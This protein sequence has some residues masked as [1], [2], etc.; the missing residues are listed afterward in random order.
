M[1]FMFRLPDG[2]ET[3][4]GGFN[5]RITLIENPAPVNALLQIYIRENIIEGN[6]IF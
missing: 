5:L 6:T 1:M 2:S 3:L 4:L